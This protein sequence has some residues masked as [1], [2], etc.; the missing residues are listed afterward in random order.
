MQQDKDNIQH[1]SLKEI[2]GEIGENIKPKK[3][4]GFDLKTGEILRNLPT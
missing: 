2:I 1:T 3:K 4:E